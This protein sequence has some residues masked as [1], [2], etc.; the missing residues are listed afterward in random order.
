FPVEVVA[1]LEAGARDGEGPGGDVLY[2]AIAERGVERGFGHGEPEGLTLLVRPVL[3][4]I[5]GGVERRLVVEQADPEGGQRADAL[6]W[7]AIGAAHFEELLHAHFREQ[8]RKVVLPILDGRQLAG[9]LGQ[10]AVEESA[11]TLA[12]AVNVFAV[13]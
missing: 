4:Q 12:G 5:P 1:G 9:E 6:P 8:G 3:D 2:G 11:E 10:P 13:A 7:R